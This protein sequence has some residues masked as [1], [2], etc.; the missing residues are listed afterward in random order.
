MKRHKKIRNLVI[1]TLLLAAGAVSLPAQDTASGTINATLINK[2]A[3]ALVFDSD[4]A[5]VVLGN[6]G[7]STASLNFGTVSAFGSLS[8]GVTRPTVLAG[9][10]TVRTLFDVNVTAGGGNS[11]NYTLS[12]NLAAV[13][14]TGFSYAVDA[15]TLTT[16][17]QSIQTNGNYGTDVQHSMNLT[18][19]TAAPGAGGPVVG[20]PISATIN[21]L[22]T[23]N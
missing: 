16:T 23:A 18:I 15:V 8:A 14:A 3:I 19:S 1:T 10:Y 11:L 17:A 6:S 20:T 9:S 21:F 12:A 7:S 22:A 2:S 4:P 13:A 5:G